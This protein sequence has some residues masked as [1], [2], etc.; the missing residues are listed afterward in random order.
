MRT[1]T[2]R[3]ALICL[4]LFV[5]SA[6]TVSAV[7]DRV[8]E[9]FLNHQ[10]EETIGAELD[11]LLDHYQRGGVA[12]LVQV[13]RDRTRVP[14]SPDL[15][16]LTDPQ[17]LLVVGNLPGL[18]DVTGRDG[19]L[20]FRT[21]GEGADRSGGR[22]PAVGVVHTLP[23]SHRLLV[24][25]ELGQWQGFRNQIVWALFWS[26]TVLLAISACGGWLVSRHVTRRL[27]VINRT[28]RTI[29]DGHLH[30]RIPRSPNDDEL[31]RLAA[32]LNDMLEQIEGLMAG[33]RDLSEDIAHDLR[34]PLNRLRGQL[35]LALSEARIEDPVRD[36]IQEAIGEAD[37]LLDMFGALLSIA[38]AE[39]GYQQ[40]PLSDVA[41]PP[42][43]RRVV[44]LYEPVAEEKHIT[45][46]VRIEVP[47]VV[48]GHDQ[49]LAQALANLVD[50][51]V[52]YTPDGGRIDVVVAPGQELGMTDVTVAD[53]GIGIP[54][55]EHERVLG[56]FIRLDWSRSTPGNGLGLALV[57][58]V[59]RLHGARLAM[60]DN[61]PGLRVRLSFP[62]A[63]SQGLKAPAERHGVE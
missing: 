42:V 56:R 53:S 46:T 26:F 36:L 31:D 59:V 54:K 7:V 58:A 61:A 34:T 5:L 13:L 45:L 52:K 4:G 12:K 60:E 22:A 35:E 25:T 41:L 37:R 6:L 2:V 8:T 33:L 21:A 23:D 57:D 19:W 44:E 20:A 40:M 15:F 29:I 28:T 24:G 14:R 11:G 9:G 47:A 17:G 48:R 30:A 16:V 3:V 27:E 1:V 49:L 55:Q 18:P 63:G 50:N 62:E 39:A 10:A 38:K 32:N 43:L 51:A